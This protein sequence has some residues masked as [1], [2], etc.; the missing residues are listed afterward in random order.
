[1]HGCAFRVNIPA[2]FFEYT[3]MLAVCHFVAQDVDIAGRVQPEGYGIKG[4]LL[5]RLA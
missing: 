1:M 2:T 5:M 4:L 3:T